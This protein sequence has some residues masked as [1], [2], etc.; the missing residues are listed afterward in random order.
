[1]G[2]DESKFLIGLIWGYLLCL[3][4]V[5]VTIYTYEIL[6]KEFIEM[7]KTLAENIGLEIYG[8]LAVLTIL[9]L[10]VTILH[11]YLKGFTKRTE[12][13]ETY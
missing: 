5:V 9:A 7:N 8:V 1:M 13:G 11:T 12:Y 2:K 10:L 6:P 4:L 3:W